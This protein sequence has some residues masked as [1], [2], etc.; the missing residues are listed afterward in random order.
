MVHMYMC[1]CFAHKFVDPDPVSAA[2][3][4]WCLEVLFS[5]MEAAENWYEVWET[6]LLSLSV[7]RKGFHINFVLCTALLCYL[8]LPLLSVNIQ[9]MHYKG[10]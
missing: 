2:S 9:S 1:V 3:W 5:C 10:Q 7:I 8:S 4:A 6:F